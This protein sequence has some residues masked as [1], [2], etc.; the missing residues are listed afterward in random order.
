MTFDYLTFV[1][2]FSCFVSLFHTWLD[3]RQIKALKKSPPK[4]TVKLYGEKECTAAI[5]YQTDRLKYGI[6]HGIWETLMGAAQLWFGFLPVTW[7][8]SAR[9]LL[10]TG[11]PVTSPLQA[12][13]WT[14]ILGGI[15]LLLGLPWSLYKTFSLE[16]K[17]GFNKT[18]MRTFI[19]DTIKSIVLGA[20][21]TPPIIAGVA[22]VLEKSGPNVALQLWAF[23]LALSIFMLSIY[24]LIQKLFNKFTPLEPGKLRSEIEGLAASL[25]FPLKKLFV[26]DGSKRSAHSNAYFFGFFKSKRIVLFDTLLEQCNNK[27]IVAVLSHELGHWWHQHTW[28]LFIIGQLQM[29]AQLQLFT[30]FRND[31]RLYTDFGFATRSTSYTTTNGGVFPPSSFVALV[32]FGYLTGPLD[33]VLSFFM[34]M[35]SRKFEYQADAFAVSLNYGK[36][37]KEALVVLNKENRG[38]P[39]VDPLYAMYNFSHPSLIERLDAIGAEM[40]KKR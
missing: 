3:S 22:Y 36:P 29:L 39:N 14:L 11:L 7:D 15:S 10:F 31:T 4:A 37:L 38:P 25:K 23:L 1:L 8:W 27:Q 24:P 28:I 40:K 20:V 12:A 5:H 30:L 13:S 19:T 32:L 33:E 16:A 21:F 6:I 35:I 18:T 34:N 17:H 9:F 2:L 26:I